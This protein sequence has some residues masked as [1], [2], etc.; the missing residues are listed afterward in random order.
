MSLDG[1]IS[2]MRVLSVFCDV[3]HGQAEASNSLLSAARQSVSGL[4]AVG[5]HCKTNRCLSGSSSALAQHFRF[6]KA[7]AQRTIL[8]F[9]ECRASLFDDMQMCIAR[10]LALCVTKSLD[11]PLFCLPGQIIATRRLANIVF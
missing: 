11:Q 7:C 10:S 6:P 3:Y 9:D 1:D 4:V 2:L 5:R 8:S